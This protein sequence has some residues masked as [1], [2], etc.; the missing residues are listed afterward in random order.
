MHS[1][2]T[3]RWGAAWLEVLIAIAFMV[4][5]FQLFPSFAMKLT[6]IVDMRYW[7]RLTWFL[8]NTGVMLLLVVVRFGPN[9]IDYWRQRPK[10]Q[11]QASS[12][13]RPIAQTQPHE[14]IR[15]LMRRDEVLRAKLRRTLALYCLLLPGLV[16]CA[17]SAIAFFKTRQ[18]LAIRAANTLLHAN[19]GIDFNDR[20]NGVVGVK[21]RV[22]SDD[23]VDVTHLGVYDQ[24][25]DGLQVDH[26][27]GIFGMTTGSSSTRALITEVSVP[28]GRHALLEGQFRW[29][30]LPVPITLTA[31]ATY[32][33]AAET[34]G[35]IEYAGPKMVIGDSWPA[36][37]DTAALRRDGFD[38]AWNPSV[39][40]DGGFDSHVVLRTKKAWPACPDREEPISGGPAH[41]P[42]NLIVAERE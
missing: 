30:A 20:E 27:V 23:N 2:R 5:V 26:R 9:I 17:A 24:D 25:R 10:A 34:F 3:D 29:V 18:T 6:E 7:S 42:A 14:D 4:L 15:V 35:E 31:G 13:V 22:S 39:V 11:T 36:A 37:F 41:G 8:V 21:F 19:P 40:G 32:V 12:E 28:Y 16:I 1:K 33:L 38:K